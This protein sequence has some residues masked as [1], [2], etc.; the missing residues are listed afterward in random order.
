MIGLATDGYTAS[1]VRRALHAES[2]AR[3]VFYRFER[4]NADK[5]PLGLLDAV[6]GS[7]SLDYNA[8]IMRTGRFTI[9][10]DPRVD[11]Q[12]ELLRACP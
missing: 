6:D 2:G 10:D 1:Q 7:I 4:L 9:R 5:V 3:E 12:A 8:D 11:W